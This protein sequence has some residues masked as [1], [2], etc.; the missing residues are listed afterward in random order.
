M[1]ESKIADSPSRVLSSHTRNDCDTVRAVADRAG[2]TSGMPLARRWAI[3]GA[4]ERRQVPASH[5]GSRPGTQPARIR[6]RHLRGSATG[7]ASIGTSRSWSSRSGR[8]TMPQ[9]STSCRRAAWSMP[10]S[11]RAPTSPQSLTAPHGD[12]GDILSRHL[13]AAARRSGAPRDDAAL[14]AA[15]FSARR[16]TLPGLPS[17]TRRR[18]V[19]ASRP[20]RAQIGDAILARKDAPASLS[21]RLRRR[22]CGERRDPGRARRGPA[23]VDPDPAAAAGAARPARADLSPSS[24]GHP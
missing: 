16:S 3:A 8:G 15:R 23:A 22:R 24:A 7:S 20:K 21:S 10:A 2:C 1:N 6:R 12:A 19:S 5:R 13:P 14:L 9:R 11:A 18:T 4:R 17:W